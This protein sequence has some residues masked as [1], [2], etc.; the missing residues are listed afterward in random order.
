MLVSSSVSHKEWESQVPARDP[1]GESSQGRRAG[2]PGSSVRLML[3]YPPG[4]LPA[5]G[6]GITLPDGGWICLHLLRL[7]GKGSW[8]N[9]LASSQLT[10]KGG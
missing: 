2:C 5:L 6:M 10:L 3:A 9:V 8:K 7:V 4:L 1:G